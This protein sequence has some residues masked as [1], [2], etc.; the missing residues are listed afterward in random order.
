MFVLGPEAIC[1]GPLAVR[2]G[3]LIASAECTFDKLTPS[4][5]SL[6]MVC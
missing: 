3:L 2:S 4:S 5:E 1:T 6:T